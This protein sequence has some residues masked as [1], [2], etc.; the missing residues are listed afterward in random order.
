MDQIQAKDKGILGKGDEAALWE[1]IISNLPDEL[2]QKRDISILFPAIGDATE[3]KVLGRKLKSMG[4]TDQEIFDACHLCDK[5]HTFTNPAKEQG[6]THVHT[7]DFLN[8][9][10]DMK[11]DAVIGNPP[12]Q[13]GSK[14]GNQ[15]KIYNDFSKK[16][17]VLTKD[18]GIVA[19]VTPTAVLKNTKRFGLM[20]EKGLKEISFLANDYFDVGVNICYWVIDR[21]HEGK[22]VV[23]DHQG[24]YEA[25]KDDLIVD[26]S[27][28]DPSF[29]K[30][31]NALK[32]IT[33]KPGTRMFTQNPVD[34]NNGKSTVQTDVFKYPIYKLNKGEVEFVTYH[35]PVPK[36]IGE[37][38]FTAS[39]TKT[40]NESSIYVGKEDF[41]AFHVSC[42][43][44]S[45]EEAE[46]IKSFILSDHFAEHSKQ[47]K[48]LD[49]YGF[50]NC[51]VHLP[52]FDKTKSWTNDEVK[53]FLESFIQ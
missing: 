31:Y 48:S 9:D 19:M 7:G 32:T 49:G 37:L 28:N 35:K 30:L 24:I 5:Y 50:N 18:D 34:A 53:E 3:V 11:F 39:I 25:G 23:H 17:C 13:D 21:N 6:F 27:V 20:D 12:Y 26:R 45:L 1:E 44:D 22:I 14:R 41:T 10:P 36:G 43:I 15:Q 4:W 40:L 52:P 16:A 51:L 33:K 42:P 8:W 38:K 47:W 2:L 46:N 29:A